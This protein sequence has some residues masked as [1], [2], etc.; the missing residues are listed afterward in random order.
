MEALQGLAASENTHPPNCGLVLASAPS[1]L[2][3]EA[4]RPPPPTHWQ[5]QGGRRPG[6][7]GM[8]GALTCPHTHQPVCCRT[9]SF[10][11]MA[12]AQG[13]APPPPLFPAAG[14]WCNSGPG[15]GWLRKGSCGPLHQEGPSC[16]GMA[17]THAAPA[18]SAD[19]QGPG[20]SHLWAPLPVPGHAGC[21]L[22]DQGHPCWDYP[23]LLP[24]TGRHGPRLRP[25]PNQ[26][27]PPSGGDRD[28]DLPPQTALSQRRNCGRRFAAQR[29]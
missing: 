2:K 6:W 3:R 10:L 1:S 23:L 22:P 25:G 29:S 24:S 16:I 7:G 15:T 13:L 8:P 27:P 5:V 26:E 9:S 19:S 14:W 17:S 4:G 18:P 21:Q 28:P 20:T 12:P 11:D